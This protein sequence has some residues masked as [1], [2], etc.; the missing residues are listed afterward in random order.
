[1]F[2]S[3]MNLPFVATSGF[4]PC[5]IGVPGFSPLLQTPN[6]LTFVLPPVDREAKPK[7]KQKQSHL[8]F[9]D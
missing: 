9:P 7:Q 2:K 4:A 1:M 5:T 6:A 8:A 3:A